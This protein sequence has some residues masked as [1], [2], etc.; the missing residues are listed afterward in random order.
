MA[1][2]TRISTRSGLAGFYRSAHDMTNARA[3]I[4]R[5]YEEAKKQIERVKSSGTNG[6]E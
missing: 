5:V 1:I 2:V 3:D 6:K 4:Q